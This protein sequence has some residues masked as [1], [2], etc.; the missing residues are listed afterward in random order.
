[1]ELKLITVHNLQLS[2]AV[3]KICGPTATWWW[4]MMMMMMIKW[5][6]AHITYVN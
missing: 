3:Y 4:M 5:R 1:M 2:G 6:M